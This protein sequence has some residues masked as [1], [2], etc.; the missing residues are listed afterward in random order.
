AAAAGGPTTTVDSPAAGA[1]VCGAAVAVTASATPDPDAVPPDITGV[2]FTE[3]GAVGGTA[4]TAPYTDTW[5]TTAVADGAATITATASDV[6]GPGPASP[7]VGVTVAN[8]PAVV[9]SAPTAG[10]TVT[11]ETVH[12]ATSDTYLGAAVT[13]VTAKVGAG[14]PVS[15]TDTAGTY[16]GDVSTSAVTGSQQLTVTTAIG[17]CSASQTVAITVS[18]PPAITLT[19][20]SGS[21]TPT[22]GGSVP[23]AADASTA[24]GS[25]RTISN[26]AFYYDA[27][28][29]AHRIVIDTTATG[30]TYDGSWDT[31]SLADGAHTVIAV[32]TDNLGATKQASKAVTVQNSV[33]VT[34]TSPAAGPV[35]GTVAI[36]ADPTPYQG[37]AITQV[38]LK[39]DGTTTL[40]TLT[41]APYTYDWSTAGYNGAHTITADVTDAL[42][43]TG[44][45]AGVD[46]TVANPPSVVLHAPADGATVGGTAVAVTAHALTDAGGGATVTLLVDGTPAG[47]LAPAGPPGDYA[48]SWDTTGLTGP[49]T[50][51]VR[52]TDAGGLSADS[53]TAHVTVSNPGPDVSFTNLPDGAHVARAPLVVTVTATPS[54]TTGKAVESVTAQSD[55]GA[56]VVTQDDASHWT[57]HWEASTLLG[58]QTLTVTAT[59]VAAVTTV[60]VRHVV[61]TAPGR[62]TLLAPKATPWGR[63]VSA[64]ATL[65]LGDGS[66]LNG[67][68]VHLQAHRPGAKTWTDVGTATTAANGV[69]ALSM[70]PT[71]SVVYRAFFAGEPGVDAVSSADTTTKVVPSVVLV[72]PHTAKLGQAV[73]GKVVVHGPDTVAY[74]VVG[75]VVGR[76]GG[77]VSLGTTKVRPGHVAPIHL[78]FGQHGTY[79]VRIT[80]APGHGIPGAVSNKVTVRA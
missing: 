76:A 26:V 30:S 18:H 19:A 79:T 39:L 63:R 49:H 40:A 9:V 41:S 50:V 23:L 77:T 36:T 29:V 10:A 11:G 2:T 46:V 45:S 58:P 17:S 60:A 75:L 34:V 65:R 33:A 74:Y 37:A 21:G 64:T 67:R 24:V 72:L 31:T 20:P 32:A 54:S 1:V 38:V 13:S 59:D 28:N 6:N 71:R 52:V 69:A 48:G 78:R 22:V 43:R 66:P 4:T 35:S 80:C 51:A 27:V 14:A 53:A 7:G 55:A 42:N 56:T 61:V 68:L 57:V 44:T 73:S 5:D 62:L 70:A 12:V 3:A 47:L 15:L 16:A 8:H 25:G